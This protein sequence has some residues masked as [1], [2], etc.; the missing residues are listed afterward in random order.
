MLSD[1]DPHNPPG[2]QPCRV[3]FRPD[4][5]S[6]EGGRFYDICSGAMYDIEGRGL[7]GDGLDLRL[8][9]FELDTEGQLTISEDDAALHLLGWSRRAGG[10]AV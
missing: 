8:V 1:I 10:I 4:L 7:Q 5:G 6:A 3:T 2:R 9:P